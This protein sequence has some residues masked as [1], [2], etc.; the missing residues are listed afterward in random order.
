MLRPA[1]R[2]VV[3]LGSPEQPGRLYWSCPDERK[4]Q[5]IVQDLARIGFPAFYVPPED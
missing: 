5:Q 1:P 2:W 3:Y 4:A